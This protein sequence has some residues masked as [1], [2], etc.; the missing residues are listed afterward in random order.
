MN[1]IDEEKE[2]V[3]S[4]EFDYSNKLAEVE[5]IV[6]LAQYFENTYQQFL[7]LCAED[8][9]KNEP[10][11]YEFQKYN[12]KNSYSRFEI[13]IREKSYNNITCKSLSSLIDTV[14]KGQLKNVSSLE[15]IMELNYRRGKQYEL[16]THENTFKLIFKPYEI[17]F[18]RNSNH[19]ESQMNQIESNINKIMEQFKTANSIFCT[20]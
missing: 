13:Y 10:L 8:E 20:K 11:K 12:Y 19:N 4:N 3:I 9:K 5:A 1:Y 7:A 16:E 17:V 18:T 15:I 14:K 2:L 6:Y